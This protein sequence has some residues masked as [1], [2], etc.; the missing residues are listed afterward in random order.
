MTFLLLV[1]PKHCK[2]V[3]NINTNHGSG[4][5]HKITKMQLTKGCTL[6]HPCTGE[7]LGKKCNRP[8]FQASG[9][10]YICNLFRAARSA[11]C[12]VGWKHLRFILCLCRPEVA[13]LRERCASGLTK[14]SWLP[15]CVQQEQL[16]GDRRSDNNTKRCNQSA[17]A[18]QKELMCFHESIFRH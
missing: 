16:Q 18:T 4:A 15:V 17:P 11:A 6:F 8:R 5:N 1:L 14:P 12:S 10:V 9:I 2:T 13:L 7:P 3:T